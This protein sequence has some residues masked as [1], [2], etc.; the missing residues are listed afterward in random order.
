MNKMNQK[1]VATNIRIPEDDLLAYRQYALEQGKS[2]SQ[3]V[4]DS[5][6]GLISRVG[7]FKIA[8]NKKKKIS[9]WDIEKYAV[10]GGDPKASQNIDK[11]VYTHP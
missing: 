10:K 7:S 5:L 11:H 6:A 2:F 1:L 3:L 9:F 8:S 4:R